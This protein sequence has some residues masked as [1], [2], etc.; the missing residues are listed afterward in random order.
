[1]YCIIILNYIA[2]CS[3]FMFISLMPYPVLQV[4]CASYVDEKH[5]LMRSN[6]AVDTEWK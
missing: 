1:M 2:S 3:F 6:F 4:L 5:R